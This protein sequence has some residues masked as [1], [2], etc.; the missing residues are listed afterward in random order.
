[1]ELKGR[2]ST[3]SETVRTQGGKAVPE[4]THR[5]ASGSGSISRRL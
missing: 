2:F 5:E 1:M 4:A 3:S